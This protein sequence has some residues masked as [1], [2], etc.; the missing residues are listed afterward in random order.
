M[1]QLTKEE[2]IISIVKELLAERGKQQ[3]HKSEVINL[4]IDFLNKYDFY[5]NI[6]YKKKKVY[7]Y[8]AFVKYVLYRALANY[9]TMILLQGEKG[10]GKSSKA[11][12]FA[13]IWCKLLGIRFSPKRHIAYN[14][15]QLI[16]KINTLNKFEPL[17]ADEAVRFA[18][19]EDWNKKENKELKKLLAQV[20]TKHLFYILCFPYKI[21]KLDKVYLDSF[22][23]Y[24]LMIFKR[25]YVDTFKKDLNP[26]FDSWRLNDFKD[27]GKI[28][29]FSSRDEILSKIKK[30]PNYWFSF[31]M[32]KPNK[33]LYE[34]YLEIRE[35]NVYNE[36]TAQDTLTEEDYSKALLLRTLRDIIDMYRELSLR[37]LSQHIKSKYDVD[38]SEAKIRSAFQD[39]EMVI[40][41][42]KGT[43][44]SL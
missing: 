26:F 17:I 1:Q 38:L 10:T 2:E 13:K 32:P 22:V 27:I 43:K 34:R 12:I 21:K 28:D 40:D 25:G 30:H 5:K 20:R 3:F 15:S 37:K 35:A 16:N 36:N 8:I 4:I 31:R 11:L 7:K 9:D 23:N 42:I 14:N 41:T 44:L 33:K 29:E 39:S 24:I 19:S 18:T 6:V